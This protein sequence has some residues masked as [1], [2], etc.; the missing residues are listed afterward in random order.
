MERFLQWEYIRKDFCVRMHW[1]GFFYM[2]AVEKDLVQQLS[3]RL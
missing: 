1:K 2:N 3:E